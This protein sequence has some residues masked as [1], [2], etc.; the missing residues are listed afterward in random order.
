MP[1]DSLCHQSNLRPRNSIGWNGRLNCVDSRLILSPEHKGR[2]LRSRNYW[3]LT[4]HPKGFLQ[5][6]LRLNHEAHLAEMVVGSQGNA[7]SQF[8]HHCKARAVGEREIL[9]AI[10]KKNHACNISAL[11]SDELPTQSCA[12]FNLS[13][14]GLRRVDA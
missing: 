12:A 4:R 1:S 3:L 7:K 9:V 14:P 13:P 10:A 8:A 6:R 2:S 11:R 5:L